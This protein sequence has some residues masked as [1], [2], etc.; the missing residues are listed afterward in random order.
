MNS[1][2]PITI[3]R[4]KEVVAARAG[5]ELER[6]RTEEELRSSLEAIKRFNHALVGRELRMIELKK[7]I[8]ELYVRT[9]QPAKYK[10]EFDSISH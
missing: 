8:N 9:G 7:E 10:L 3:A 5:S 6:R 1:A 4:I 2:G